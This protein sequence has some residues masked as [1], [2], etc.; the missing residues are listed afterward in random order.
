MLPGGHEIF[1]FGENN[2]FSLFVVPE[3]FPQEVKWSHLIAV[4]TC[5]V[6]IL[7]ATAVAVLMCWRNRGGNAVPYQS[8]VDHLP[9]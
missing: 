4:V 8:H 6:F 1:V 5:A 7:L 3:C 2:E 9:N